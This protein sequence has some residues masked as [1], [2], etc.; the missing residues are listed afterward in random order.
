MPTIA[1]APSGADSSIDGTEKVPVS[2]SKYTLISSILT[3]IA[4]ATATLTNKTITSPSITG[5]T[6]PAVYEGD[7]VT[8]DGDI[9]W[10]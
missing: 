8:S 6:N 9:V 10:T 3:Y 7:V 5:T 1:N 2:G 4:A